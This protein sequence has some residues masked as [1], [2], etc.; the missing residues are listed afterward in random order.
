MSIRS[1]C[2][3]HKT[4]KMNKHRTEQK[5]LLQSNSGRRLEV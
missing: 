4:Q 2:D 1:I 3:E 5:T